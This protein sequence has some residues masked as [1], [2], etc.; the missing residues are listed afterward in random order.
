MVKGMP[1][2][3]KHFAGYE[4]AFVLIGGVACDEWFARYGREFRPTLDFD[5]VLVLEA[6]GP[7]FF[8]HFWSFI[9]QGRYSSCR[10]ADG[11]KVYFRFE[12]PA[13]TEYPVLIELFSPVPLQIDPFPGQRIV[14]IPAGEDVYSLSA[15]LMDSDY[16]R[17]VMDQRD[18][19]EGL[20][21]I[22]PAGLIVLKA[23]AWLDMSKR[24]AEGDKSVD[25]DDVKKHRADVFRLASILPVGESV[26]LPMAL[27][28]DLGRFL[29]AFPATSPEWPAILQSLRSKGIRMPADDLLRVLRDHFGIPDGTP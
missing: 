27:A 15:I 13:G 6:T 14:P 21:L 20:P 9:E 24:R 4:D 19:V 12:K 8:R 23:K 2:F 28:V 10:R 29:A 5:M 1:I 16:Y 3:R 26:Q 17:F 25:E 7:K 11:E 18:Q 22:K